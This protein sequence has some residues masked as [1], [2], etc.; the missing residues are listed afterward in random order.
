MPRSKAPPG[1]SKQGLIMA[2]VF[3]VLLSVLLAVATY[4]GFA[5]QQTLQDQKK[6]AEVK[7]KSMEGDR[8]AQ[9]LQKAVYRLA[10]GIGN[11]E[12]DEVVTGTKAQL[13]EPYDDAVKSLKELQWGDNQNKPV[14]SYVEQITT[15]TNDVK[16]QSAAVAKAN[17]DAQKAIDELTG[18]L[19]S[20]SDR[21]GCAAGGPGQGERDREQGDRQEV[22]GLRNADQNQPAV[23]G[24]E[25]PSSRRDAQDGKEEQ[26]RLSPA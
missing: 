15:L 1:E 7:Y 21:E 8:N 22:R 14:K 19:K 10:I 24:R 18:Q 13:K 23:G 6:Q 3:F 4:Y 9:K 20:S 25:P 16:T 12:D 5:D 2:L 11:Q 26:D 17:A